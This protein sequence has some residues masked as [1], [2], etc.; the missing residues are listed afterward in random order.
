[1][2]EV[3][4]KRGRPR[5]T[6]VQE[7]VEAHEEKERQEI[8]QMVLDERAKRKEWDI[9]LE[10]EIEF[11]DV[12]LSYEI[13]GYKPINKTEYSEFVFKISNKEKSKFRYNV[14]YL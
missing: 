6:Q 14:W 10:D 5:K 12:N 11:F 1:M 9:S 8:H 7:M 3:K 13:T 2:E 4:K